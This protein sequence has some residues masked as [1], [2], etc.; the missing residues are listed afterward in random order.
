MVASTTAPSVC[1]V[2]RA[3]LSMP[4]AAP[5]RASGAEVTMVW[6][7]GDWYSAKPLPASSMRQTMSRVEGASGMAASAHRPQANMAMPMP[8][9][10]PSA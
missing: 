10:S 2:S 8:P 3:E 5:L 4:P 7:L 1:P 6:L 9:S